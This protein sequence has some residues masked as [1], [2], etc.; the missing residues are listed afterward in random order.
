MGRVPLDR[1]SVRWRPGGR[2]DYAGPLRCKA[3]SAGLMRR[4]ITDG[5]SFGSNEPI[6][7]PFLNSETI[8][9][10]IMIGDSHPIRSLD[11]DVIGGLGDP[12]ETI[13]PMKNGLN[14]GGSDSGG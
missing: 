10:D 5:H 1:S 14:I 7:R 6:V 13:Y 4:S 9:I 12:P 8:V 3:I 11:D 2:A